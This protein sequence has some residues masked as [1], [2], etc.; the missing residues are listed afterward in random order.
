MKPVTNSHQ[1]IASEEGRIRQLRLKIIYIQI[2]LPVSYFYQVKV[3]NLFS[4]VSFLNMIHIDP[5]VDICI[6]THL[7]HCN[8]VTAPQV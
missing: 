8:L 7:S 1:V 6:V 3:T 4:T 2:Q 5:T